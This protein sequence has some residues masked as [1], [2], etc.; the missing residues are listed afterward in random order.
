[1]SDS[2]CQ[3]EAFTTE[4]AIARLGDDGVP[5]RNYM[6]EIKIR[7]SQCGEPFH[8]VGLPAGIS[9]TRPMVGVDA[10]E[11]RAPIAPGEGPTAQSIRVEAGSSCR[12]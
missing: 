4:C 9:F 2:G 8:F 12:S 10:T 1:M 3:H 11:L 6:A 7:C 5:I